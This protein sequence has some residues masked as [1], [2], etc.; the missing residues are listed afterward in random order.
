[1]FKVNEE[2]VRLGRKYYTSPRR[3]KKIG[4]VLRVSAYCHVRTARL[5]VSSS[6]T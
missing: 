1:M 2:L 3:W 4:F 5:Y 6:T